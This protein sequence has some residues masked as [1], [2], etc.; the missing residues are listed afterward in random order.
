MRDHPG[1]DSDVSGALAEG[2]NAHRR[3][4]RPRVRFLVGVGVIALL[5]AVGSAGWFLWVPNW[6]PPLREGEQYG[7]D[8]SRHQGA[9]DWPRVA[10]DGIAF[11]Y[12]KA[13]ALTSSTS[14]STRIGVE[15]ARWGSIEGHITSSLSAPP[16]ADQ[17]R[18]FLDVAPPQID[19]LAPAVDLELAGNCS[20]RPSTAEVKHQL[21][22][23]LHVVEEAWGREVVLYVG[24]D[25]EAVYPVQERRDHPLWLR[26]F[27]LRPSVDGWL[28]WQLHGHAHVEGIASG[29]DLDVMRGA[30]GSSPSNARSSNLEKPRRP[31]Q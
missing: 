16:G 27:L 2:A 5:A 22:A 1:V 28:I 11:A 21:E 15:P 7:V 29:V 10:R 3:F 18:H 24:D 19:T 25:F 12:I 13:R 9:I 20:A 30:S 23:F 14:G 4:R 6:R 31:T 26:R 17:A 8:V